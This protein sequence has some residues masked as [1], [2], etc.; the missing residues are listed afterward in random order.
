MSLFQ[1]QQLRRF[2]IFP[3]WKL[4]GRSINYTGTKERRTIAIFA[5]TENLYNC[6]VHM[7]NSLSYITS[8]SYP[9]PP[10]QHTIP[11]PSNLTLSHR[12]IS[13]PN[14][15][16][17]IRSHIL[18]YLLCISLPDLTVSYVS[19][20]Y[21]TSPYL[22]ILCHPNIILPMYLVRNCFLGLTSSQSIAANRLIDYLFNESII[23]RFEDR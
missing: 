14:L 5:Q 16:Y 15:S 23:C 17:A 19:I 8:L 18:S 10:T 11:I 3:L 6:F 13:Y 22:T 12:I 9:S 20:L 21:L 1:L 2:R 7:R 4:T